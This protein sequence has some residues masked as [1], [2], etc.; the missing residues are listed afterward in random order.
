MMVAGD[1]HAGWARNWGP[2]GKAKLPVDVR[3]R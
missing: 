1:K 3:G 2:F